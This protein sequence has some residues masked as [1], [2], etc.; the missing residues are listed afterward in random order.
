MGN[1]RDRS[2]FFVKG[3]WALVLAAGLAA[4]GSAHG[5]ASAPRR[6]AAKPSSRAVAAPS[7]RPVAP[8]SAAAKPAPTPPAAD[9]VEVRVAPVP[10]PTGP[11]SPI[12]FVVRLANERG[13]QELKSQDGK[14]SVPPGD[15]WLTGW[16]I[17]LPDAQGRRW[18]ARGGIMGAPPLAAH[19][20]ARRG[21]PV[22]LRLVAPLGTAVVPTV[23][24][25]TVNFV[26]TFVGT[27]GDRCYEV[28][29]DDQRPPLPRM[30]ILDEHGQLVE[31]VDFSFG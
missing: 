22:Q 28:S 6:P 5:A 14:V 10:S 30:K 7:R 16:A 13:V 23:K 9:R 26:T 31:Q 8:S 12:D 15:Y 4:G 25:R 2:A 11:I 21:R 29:V 3:V 18:K 24:G 19:V 20:A 1:S 17:T 27:T